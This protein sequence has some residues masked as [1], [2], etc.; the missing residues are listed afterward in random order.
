MHM[1][2]P[3]VSPRPAVRAVVHLLHRSLPPAAPRLTAADERTKW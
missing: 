1:R 3:H 2:T